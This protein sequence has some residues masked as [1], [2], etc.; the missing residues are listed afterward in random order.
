MAEIKC[1]VTNCYFNKKLGCTAPA[2]SVNGRNADE[3]RSTSCHTFIEQKPGL[4]SSVEEPKSDTDILC[5]ATKCIY[6][7]SERCEANSIIVNG[8]NASVPEETYCSTFRS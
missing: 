7:E 8:K 1:T 2:L 4:R 5:A 6:N 3:S